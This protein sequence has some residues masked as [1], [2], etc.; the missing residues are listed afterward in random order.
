[1]LMLL[2]DP[3]NAARGESGFISLHNNDGTAHN[4]YR[5]V[6]ASG[7]S[8]RDYL[9]WNV[10]PWQVRNPDHLASEA[11]RAHPYLLEFLEL[12]DPAPQ[13]VI[14]MGNQA[15]DAWKE[16]AVGKLSPRL[17][18]LEDALWC[19]HPSPRRYDEPNPRTGR[20]TSDLVT[21]T[22]AV[23]AMQM[24]VPTVD[25]TVTVDDDRWTLTLRSGEHRKEFT[26]TAPGGRTTAYGEVVVEGFTKL[27]RPCH[28]RVHLTDPE[29]TA[30]VR[31]LLD[32]AGGG[33]TQQWRR[34]SSKQRSVAW[35][36]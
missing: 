28:V 2:Q 3:S 1:M 27:T 17:A 10:I 31:A 15:R 18:N 16:A 4:V 11:R 35:G 32:G 23:A 14:L 26:G 6:E 30:P 21:E 9:P 8:Y 12:L 36:P 19:P 20:L 13:V 33:L 22:F 24:A 7:L 34:L 29:Q 25:L 5:S